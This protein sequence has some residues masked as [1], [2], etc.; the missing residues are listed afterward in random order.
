MRQNINYSFRAL[1]LAGF[2]RQQFRDMEK[3]T[4]ILAW[5]MVVMNWEMTKA[6]F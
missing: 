4:R 3:T 5:S 1:A 2:T 6:G